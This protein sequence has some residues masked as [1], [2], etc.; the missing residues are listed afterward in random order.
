MTSEQGEE[1]TPLLADTEADLE[2]QQQQ[3]SRRPL[4]HG[5]GALD[6]EE[7]E[8]EAGDSDDET[9]AAAAS[10]AS[11][12]KSHRRR[13]PRVTLKSILYTLLLTLICATLLALALTHLI[14]GR[15]LSRVLSDPHHAGPRM[16]QAGLITHGPYH[17]ELLHS[18]DAGVDVELS[19]FGGVDVRRALEAEGEGEKW[20]GMWRW[21]SRR[22]G[23]VR[24]DVSAADVRV[25]RATGQELLALA[26]ADPVL[27]PLSYGG[28][29][30]VD[31]V[32]EEVK[33]R[34]RVGVSAPEEVVKLAL[35]A[36][37]RE[38][39]GVSVEVPRVDV[40]VGGKWMRKTASVSLEDLV[41]PLAFKGEFRLL[42]IT[43]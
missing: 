22:A 29:D 16:A 15:L 27:L 19:F 23:H 11:L 25:H 2:Q 18:T 31:V 34:V 12:S 21:A 35:E 41:Q 37:E 17:A 36:W 39:V 24:V 9:A 14:F 6:S 3:P 20:S 43:L 38:E 8:D 4:Y 28:V 1:Q 32:V 13:S 26:V 33:M 40:S 7:E 5:R 10:G 30:D 42:I